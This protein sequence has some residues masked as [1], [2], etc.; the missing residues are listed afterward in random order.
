MY[1][2]ITHEIVNVYLHHLEMYLVSG[3]PL[4]KGV[5]SNSFL[6]AAVHK[7]CLLAHCYDRLFPIRNLL[8]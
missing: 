7:I 1:I 6:G 5:I 8:V 2:Y 4:C 3:N